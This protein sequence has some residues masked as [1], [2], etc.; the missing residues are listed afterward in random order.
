MDEFTNVVTSDSV[1]PVEDEA[2]LAMKAL[3]ERTKRI[4]ELQIQI[5]SLN[6]VYNSQ[7]KKIDYDSTLVYDNKNIEP[8]N[9]VIIHSFMRWEDAKTTVVKLRANKMKGYVL[10]NKTKKSYY[11]YSEFYKKMEPALKDMEKMRAKGFNSWVLNYE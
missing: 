10:Y 2:T 8:G 6:Q 3:N 5:D 11:I 9:Y 1:I 4:A 7:T